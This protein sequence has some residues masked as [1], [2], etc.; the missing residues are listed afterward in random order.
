LRELVDEELRLV[1]VSLGD[2]IDL[3]L[4]AA[5]A[6]VVEERRGCALT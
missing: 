6:S 3:G 1:I 4:T 5:S 2:R